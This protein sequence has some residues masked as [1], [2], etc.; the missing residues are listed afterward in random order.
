MKKGYVAGIIAAFVFLLAACG[1]EA[2]E[3]VSFDINM[4][5]YTFSPERLSLKVGQE[6]T[7]NLSNASQLQHEI[8]FGREMMKMENRPAGYMEDMFEAGGVE[9][10]VTQ[11][12]EPEHEHEEE[13]HS[14]FMVALPTDGT[15]TMKFIVTEGMLGEWEMGCF[16][17]DGVHYDAGMIGSV[18]VTQ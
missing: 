1:G 15:G 18:S 17:Q 7:L 6:V 14:G 9:P 3:A 5:E 10:E 12:G 4:T 16:E 11:E 13:M 8:M 2:P